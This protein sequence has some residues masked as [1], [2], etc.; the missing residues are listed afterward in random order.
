[1]RKLLCI[2]LAVM[3]LASTCCALTPEEA[4]QDL[5][6]DEETFRTSA[7][8]EYRC[9]QKEQLLELSAAYFRRVYDRVEEEGLESLVPK[10]K[11]DLEAVEARIPVKFAVF[12]AGKADKEAYAEVKEEITALRDRGKELWNQAWKQY[13]DERYGLG[14]GR[15]VSFDEA[16]R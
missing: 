6:M 10:A 15:I 5:A 12:A 14:C 4:A 3:L 11:A 2:F 9:A 13:G 7:V 1:M 16:V 8:W